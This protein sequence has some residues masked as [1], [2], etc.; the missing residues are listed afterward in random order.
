M[1]NSIYFLSLLV[2]CSFF[3]SVVLLKLTIAIMAKYGVVDRPNHRRAHK[4]ITPRGGGITLIITFSLLMIVAEYQ[5]I[6]IID[7]SLSIL[8]LLIPIALISFLDDLYEMPVLSRLIIHTACSVFAVMWLVHP[9][10]I[11]HNELSL[12]VDLIIGAFAL[13][14]FLNFYN[15]L[16]GIDGITASETIHLS[17]TILILCLMM[18]DV[19]PNSSL[20]ISIACILLGWSCGFALFNWPPA[21][22]FIGDVGSISLGFILGIC[23][24][25][26]ATAGDRLFAACVIASL[27][28][29]ADAG[30]TLV[31]R[32]VKGEKIWQPHLQ[33]FFQKAVKK[34]LS[35]KMVTL[36]IIKCNFVL[37]LLSVG[38]LFYP[39]ICTILALINVAVT[40]IKLA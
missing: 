33:H 35:H 14:T 17:S 27:Y 5:I 11:L 3:L 36:T 23:F 22:I 18:H 20:I 39:V 30:I 40:L 13:L 7:Y 21:R 31:I 19:I 28:Y 32:L 15:F 6:G 2:I 9:N 38:A 16:D 37:M 10:K 26:I 4:R 8:T 1:T 25:T 29:I 34:G 24:L 12:T